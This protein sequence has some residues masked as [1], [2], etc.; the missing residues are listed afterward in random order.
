MIKYQ[1]LKL[2]H[3]FKACISGFPEEIMLKFGMK[4]ENISIAKIILICIGSKQWP[5][6]FNEVYRSG[7]TVTKLRTRWCGTPTSWATQHTTVCPD[8]C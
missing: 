7:A 1:R 8:T 6:E 5:Q 2:S 4:V 3:F